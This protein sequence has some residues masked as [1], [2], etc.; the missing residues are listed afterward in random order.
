MKV[1]LLNSGAMTDHSPGIQASDDSRLQKEAM[2]VYVGK[3]DSMDGEVE[4]TPEDLSR[5]VENHNAEYTRFASSGTVN[6]K[7]CPPI[8]LDH[9]TSARDTVG[10]VVGQLRIGDFEG[11][12]ALFG[13]VVFLGKENADRV[14]DGRWTHLSI[15]ADLEAG[16]L[17]ELTVTPFPAAPNAS[18]LKGKRLMQGTYRNFAYYVEKDKSGESYSAGLQWD[19][20]SGWSD[21]KDGFASEA[22]ASRYIKG[23]IDEEWKTNGKFYQ[24][25]LDKM[26]KFSKGDTVD[27]EKMKKHLMEKEKMSAEEADHK[28]SK[29]SDEEKKELS[30][31]CDEDKTSMAAEETETEDEGEDEDKD[32]ESKK[33]KMQSAKKK[34]AQLTKGFKETSAKVSLEAKK[35]RLSGRI[36]KLRSQGKI[37]PA[38]QKEINVEKIAKLSSEALDA[39]FEVM[40][41]RQPVVLV[42]QYGRNQAEDISNLAKEVQEKK[43]LSEMAESMHFS[44]GIARRLANGT[45]TSM[46]GSQQMGSAEVGEDMPTSMDMEQQLMHMKHLMES[47]KHEEGMKH[48]EKML[49]H[50]SKE[51]ASGGEHN[52][53]DAGMPE[54]SMKHLSA[55][56]ENMEEL[57]NKFDE[58]VKLADPVLGETET[59]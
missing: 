3:F 26:S 50:C 6:M 54:S 37:T 1:R 45:V 52:P 36:A 28:L 43:L 46:D 42:G 44:K 12:P 19:S 16:K 39:M 34:W 32:K 55:L 20:G 47:G 11:V 7:D 33:A 15:G 40:G 59:A 9:S 14:K 27:K 5:L 4:V 30:A 38:E 13:N 35:I 25:D 49:T 29:M 56:A 18:L 8:Q 41:K 31:K 58:L 48:L 24:N 23:C 22:E 10:R 2:L 53:S 17:N 21:E 51:K 57:Q